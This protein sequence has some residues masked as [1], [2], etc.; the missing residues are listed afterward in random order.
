[1]EK[2]FLTGATGY[3]GSKIALKAA[4][5][6]YTIH[7]L[8][9]NPNGNNVPKHLQIKLFRGDILDAESIKQAMMG[10]SIVMHTAAMT[11]LVSR[12]PDEIYDVNVEGTRNLLE[13]SIQL[14]I[15]RFIFTSTCAVLG[16]SLDV[17]LT[18]DD[19]RINP[20]ENDYEIS[21]YWAEELVK[22]YHAEGLFTITLSPP[23]VFGHGSI[24]S[25][26]AL[27]RLIRK[28]IKN[29]IMI[30]PAGNNSGNFAFVE[31]VVNG[32]ILALKHG[33]SGQKYILGGENLSYKTFF[34]SIGK[35]SHTTLKLVPV[36]RPVLTIF[37][38]INQ[39]FK[40]LL[41]QQ[42][43]FTPA[44][45]RRIFQ[46]RLL[47]SQKA[48]DELHYTITPFEEAFS[49]TINHLKNRS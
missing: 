15:S 13:A 7:A 19:P 5:L 48:M 6:G 14:G 49:Q 12:Q 2:I 36:S 8:V 20:F 28:A 43:H 34:S 10:C 21:K 47:N 38:W 46:N 24:S 33:I 30:I 16:N 41:G 35:F 1:M 25:G 3:M 23:I 17:P 22:E 29:H 18:E 27:S 32:H 37:S 45:V 11:K 26:N 40:R 44:A 4:S 39:I 42:T 31:D 9:R